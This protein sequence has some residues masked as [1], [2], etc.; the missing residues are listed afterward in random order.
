MLLKLIPGIDLKEGEQV[1]DLNPKRS[2]SIL[3]EVQSV[4]I[5]NKLVKMKPLTCP[6]S[7]TSYIENKEGTITFLMTSFEWYK[8]ID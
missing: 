6:V 7:E 8:I 4:D 5:K 1:F 2:D 3:M